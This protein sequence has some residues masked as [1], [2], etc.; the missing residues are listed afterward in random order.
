MPITDP[1]DQGDGRHAQQED[2]DVRPRSSAFVPKALPCQIRQW[3]TDNTEHITGLE[4]VLPL[5][6]HG[7]YSVAT[8]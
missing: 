6:F 1:A 4:Q 2:K 3:I 7:R 5:L 8:G